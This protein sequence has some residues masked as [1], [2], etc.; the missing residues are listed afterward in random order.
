LLVFLLIQANGSTSRPNP[1]PK[2][3]IACYLK[4]SAGNVDTPVA[5]LTLKP[6]QNKRLISIDALQEVKRQSVHSLNY[7]D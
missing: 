6:F 2:V 3:S 5:D 4:L 1:L 7:W